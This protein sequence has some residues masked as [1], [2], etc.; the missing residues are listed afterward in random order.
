MKEI[1]T[2]IPA[3]KK[4]GKALLVAKPW[5]GGLGHYVYSALQDFFEEVEWLKTYPVGWLDVISYRN[6]KEKW[7]TRLT[8]KIAS[9]RYDIAFFINTLA[10]FSALEKSDKHIVWLTDDPR[11]VLGHLDAFGKVYLADAG[12]KD[13]I[14][15][16]LKDG[17][18][19]GIL[20]F[21]YLPRIHE[22]YSGGREPKGICFIGNRDPKRDVFLKAVIKHKVHIKVYGN[23]FLQDSLFWSFPQHFLPSVANSKMGRIYARYSMSLNIHAQVV[24]HGTNMRTY[25]CAGYGIPQMVEYRPGLTDYFD[26]DK[27]IVVFHSTDELID[28]IDAFTKN[29][30][31]FQ[32]MAINAR[33]R[34]SSE[35]SYHHRI[36]TLI[37]GIR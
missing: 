14:K 9:T 35:H 10:E 23:Y 4:I 18:F 13:D 33:R 17:R 34:A 11:P 22:P 5:K 8:E 6:G 19:G 28:K 7:R 2:A 15:P 16:H 26:A 25:E 29:K 24:R 27:E 37:D 3:K 1:R 21:A 31:E 32:K 20:P 30:F 36:S 12:Y